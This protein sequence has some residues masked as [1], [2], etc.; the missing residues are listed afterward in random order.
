MIA[1][2]VRHVPLLTNQV[3]TEKLGQGIKRVVHARES[4][5]LCHTVRGGIAKGNVAHPLGNLGVNFVSR[6][7]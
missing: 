4:R 1:T 5:R 2:N 6:V 7:I 3:L